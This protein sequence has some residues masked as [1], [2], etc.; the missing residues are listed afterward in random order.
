MIIVHQ[1]DFILNVLLIG[2]LLS[3]TTGCLMLIFE[4]HT[5][6]IN[7]VRI[8]GQLTNTNLLTLQDTITQQT[9]GGL[10]RTDTSKL[11]LALLALPWIKTT[12]VDKQWPDT[13]VIK[14]QEYLPIAKWQNKFID[15]EGNIVLAEQKKLNLPKFIVPTEYLHQMIHYYIE[16]IPLIAGLHIREFGYDT[17]RAWYILLD[18]GMELWLGNTDIKNRLNRFIKKYPY[19]SLGSNSRIDL[20]YSN[21]IAIY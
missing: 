17:L 12:Q 19:K 21:G 20:R 15:I 6:P 8:K 2:L 5:L 11:H 16:F 4:P 1:L 10:L 18:N 14:I 9:A 7:M 3:L 13:I